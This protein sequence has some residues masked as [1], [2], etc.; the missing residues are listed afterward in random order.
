MSHLT[1]NVSTLNQEQDISKL[2]SINKQNKNVIRVLTQG[3]PHKFIST[4]QFVT[5]V[6]IILQAIHMSSSSKVLHNFL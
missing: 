5:N 3:T 2:S 6:V 4:E 1:G